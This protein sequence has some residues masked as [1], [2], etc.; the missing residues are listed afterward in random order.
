M[1][2]ICL[3]GA[4]GSIGTQS[5]DVFCAYPHRFQLV[6]ASVGHK[7]AV[8]ERIIVEFK[9][10]HVCC[11][12]QVDAEK[13]KSKYPHVNVYY[14]DVGLLELVQVCECDW[15]VCAL[16]G[17]SGFMPTVKAIE[18]GKNIALANKETLVAGGQFIV[19]LVKK[20]GVLL[21][22]IDSEHSALFQCLSTHHMH[23]VQQ[24]AITA[25]GGSFRDLTREQ[26][27]HVTKA[28]AL[29][30][31]NWSMGDKITIDSAT[32]MNK[33][34]E[35]I[36]AHWLFG[37]GYDQI[38][39]LIAKNS[40]VHGL[41]EFKDHSIL[42]QIASS[43]MRLPIL[44]ALSAHEHLA[45][46]IKPLDLES[47]LSIELLP[48]N[49][50]RYPVFKRALDCAKQGGN[51]PTLLNAVNEIGVSAFL[52]DKISF[53]EL[54]Q[55]ILDCIDLFEFAPL[56]QLHDVLRFDQ[57]GR[58]LATNLLRKKYGY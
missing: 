36:E 20:H 11:L 27:K 31:P 1:K 34:F 17:F 4:S 6:G 37:L 8:L 47:G 54:E 58:D 39:V 7:I 38:K 40:Q 52:N 50:E 49:L 57:I 18:L 9:C 16:L 55:F 13:I 30:H 33:A 32:M 26:L 24:V 29:K 43:D 41:I 22:P 35:V 42:A 12:N 21:T 14:G 56:D 28:E 15:V 51:L 25:S 46:D 53:Y 2:K 48:V 5:L 45:L 23:E 3:L 44:Y 10:E 19:D